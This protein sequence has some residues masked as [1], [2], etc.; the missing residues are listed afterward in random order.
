[1]AEVEEFGIF[2]LHFLLIFFSYLTFLLP[3]QSRLTS[4]VCFAVID[5]DAPKSTDVFWCQ[6]S[7][8]FPLDAF[9]CWIKICLA[10]MAYLF[11]RTNWLEDAWGPV[12]RE[13]SI[14]SSNF[15]VWVPESLS[16]QSSNFQVWVSESMCCMM[17]LVPVALSTWK[18]S[19]S[20]LWS[21]VVSRNCF[22]KEIDIV[23]GSLSLIFY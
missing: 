13:L 20:K 1:M 17:C 5:M 7:F 2:Y 9:Q 4:A 11:H 15:R 14:Q 16:I 22:W 19:D 3:Q 10:E 8:M 6:K 18:H 21:L 23:H 12:A